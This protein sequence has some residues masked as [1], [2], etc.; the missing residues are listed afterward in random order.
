MRIILVPRV[1]AAM[2]IAVTMVVDEP[3][4]TRGEAE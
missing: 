1:I 4:R 3:L 2:A